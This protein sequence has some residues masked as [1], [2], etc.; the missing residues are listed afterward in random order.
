MGEIRIFAYGSLMYEPE[1]PEEILGREWVRLSGHRRAFNKWSI[2]RGCHPSAARWPEVEVPAFFRTER[3]NRSLV[4]GTEP[5][6]ELVG[7]SVVYPQALSA[8]LLRRA[9]RREGYY[10]D[11][12][13]AASGYL[14]R[15]V[16]VCRLDTGAPSEAWTYLRN[17]DSDFYRP[18]LDLLTVARVLVRA[19]PRQQSSKKVK[20][21]GYFINIARALRQHG[22]ADPYV[23]ALWSALMDHSGAWSAELRR[24]LEDH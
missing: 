2:V 5:S 18:G 11:R 4:L 24:E 9:D 19:T 22:V 13:P 15:L 1:Y 3:L 17:P 23:E 10:P 14:R 16:Q 7:L 20:G 12:S 6:G 8:E 21:V